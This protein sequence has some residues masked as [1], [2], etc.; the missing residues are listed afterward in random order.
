MQAICTK[1]VN[2]VIISV[3]QRLGLAINQEGTTV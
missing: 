3:L 1:V 2:I